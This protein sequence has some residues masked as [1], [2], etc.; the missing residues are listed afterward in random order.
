G[1]DP[2]ADDVQALVARHYRWVSTFSTPNREAYVNLGQMYV[3]D[4]RYAANYDKH[5]AGAST[6]VLDAMKV[7]AE[8]NL[9]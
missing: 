8:R 9:A 3:D 5:G 1:A 2:G 6:F 7:Y 4:P